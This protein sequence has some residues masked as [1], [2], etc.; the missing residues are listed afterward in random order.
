MTEDKLDELIDLR[1][2]IKYYE[3]QIN[4]IRYMLNWGKYHTFDVA[5]SRDGTHKCY[6]S[7]VHSENKKLIKRLCRITLK[8]YKRGLKELKVQLDNY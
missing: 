2:K 8:F 5:F 1:G 7:F 3:N 6:V 4:D